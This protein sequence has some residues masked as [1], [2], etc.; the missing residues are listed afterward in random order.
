M[1]EPIIILSA[2]ED[3]L[4]IYR[5]ILDLIEDKI[6]LLNKHLM[7]FVGWDIHFFKKWKTLWYLG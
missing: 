4:Y 2:I 5:I 1:N 3:I 7:I 6:P